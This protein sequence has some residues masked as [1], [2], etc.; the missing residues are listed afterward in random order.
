MC[1]EEMGEEGDGSE[2]VAI[3]MP[4]RLPQV[5]AP[6]VNPVRVIVTSE[7]APKTTSPVVITMAVKVG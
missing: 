2:L 1:P 7:L 5:N 3:V 4:E 6:M